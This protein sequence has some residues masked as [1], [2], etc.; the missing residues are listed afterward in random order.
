MIPSH[1][2]SD[3]LSDPHRHMIE[4]F[5]NKINQYRRMFSRFDKLD[6]RYLGFLCFVTVLIW[7]RYNVNTT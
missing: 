5:I 7:L 4:C 1:T 3:T 6:T 2:R